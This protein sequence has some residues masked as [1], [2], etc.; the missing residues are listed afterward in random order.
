[1]LNT[2]GRSEDPGSTKITCD[3]GSGTIFPRMS[4]TI[5]KPRRLSRDSTRLCGKRSDFPK[6][7]HMI[8][9]T[10]KCSGEISFVRV[11]PFY[12]LDLF[13]VNFS[14]ESEILTATATTTTIKIKL[15]KKVKKLT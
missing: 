1:M 15:T 2:E 3:A 11:S 13:F 9:K 10:R 8:A 12:S 14:D 5:Q 4:D 7:R 6:P